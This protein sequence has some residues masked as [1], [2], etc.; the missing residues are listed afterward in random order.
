MG[1]RCLYSMFAAFLILHVWQLLKRS[2]VFYAHFK[3]ECETFLCYGGS[4][5]VLV[6]LLTRSK[7]AQ[8]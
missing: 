1:Q 7:D 8:W 5:N 3:F 6:H 2:R 4:E